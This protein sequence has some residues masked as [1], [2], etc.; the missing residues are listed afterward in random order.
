MSHEQ[1][2][3]PGQPKPYEV[4]GF[5]EQELLKWR[6]SDERLK[7]ILNLEM[8][9]VHAIKESTNI[10]GEFMFVTASRLAGLQRIGMTFYGLGYHEHRER[11]VI[12][13][14]FWY[15]TSPSSEI[16][17]STISKDE[18][19]TVLQERLERIRPEIRLDTQTNYGFLFEK[20]ADQTDDDA[21][22]AVMQT[23]GDLSDE[24]NDESTTVSPTGKN[25][26]DQEAR[27]KL[28]ELYSGEEM[29]L[30][31]PAQVK[32]FTPD[33]NWTWYASEFDGEDIFFGLVS[34]HVVELGYFSLAEL[35]QVRGPMGLLIER[36]LHFEPKS[37]R[38]LMDMHN[39]E[40]GG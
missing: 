17:R 40:R 22:L 31:T 24:S 30:E 11:W 34:G 33:S 37:L 29:G 8:T 32:F 38:E 36:D 27:D 25:L 16:V 9:T 12:D 23:L 4:F 19:E 14:W 10:Y 6:V 2:S 13:E 18:A 20:F 28:P 7:E 21:A 15:Q 1:P 3:Q 5:T 35:Q 26:L 39:K